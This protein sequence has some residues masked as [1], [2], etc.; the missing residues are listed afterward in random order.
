[1]LAELR[2][3]KDPHEVKLIQHAAKVT[4]D[5][6]CLAI[7]A[8]RAG[9]REYEIRATLE[10]AFQQHG[11][12][13]GFQSIVA[14]GKSAATLHYV[15]ANRILRR[16]DLILLDCGAEYQNYS[17]DISRVYPVSG[18]FTDEQA[19]LYNV[20]LDAQK[21][22]INKIKDGVKIA[23]VYMAAARKLTAGLRRLKVL[24]GDT[25]NLIKKGA[26]LPYFMHSIGHSLGLDVHDIGKLRGNNRATLRKGMVFTV[27]PGLYF[28]KPVKDIP[29]CGIRIEDDV[30]VTS[31]GCKIL[32]RD[33]PK[34]IAQLEAL[35]DHTA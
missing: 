31:N 21:A 15:T 11:C 19:E 10:G 14:T 16:R 1:M 25:A 12:E 5:A 13:V 17:A 3:Y 32:T 23:T 9:M 34:E 27:E 28:S 33:C 24:H 29:A 6:I 26:Y 8:T 7:Q 35:M 30:L 4:S 20:V 2:L 18:R 22:A